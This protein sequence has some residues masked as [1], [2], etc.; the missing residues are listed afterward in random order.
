MCGYVGSGMTRKAKKQE[1]TLSYGRM[2]TDTPKSYA[3]FVVYRDQGSD[4]SCAKVGE[5]LG[6]TTTMIENWCSQHNWVA[7]V[8]M[9]DKE[10]EGRATKQ[11]LMDQ[12]AARIRHMRM[13]R[14]QQ[15]FAEGQIEKHAE[16]ADQT[17][18][19]TIE[20]DKAA[21]IGVEAMKGERLILGDPTERTENTGGLDWSNLDAEEIVL[22]KALIVKLKGGKD[23]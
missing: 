7:R 22:F 14:K 17:D 23:E 20:A 1:I 19:P 12:Q 5:V 6:K 3:A 21:K 15:E 8:A 13:L 9:W 4:R 2:D 16:L 11:E 18:T 10:I